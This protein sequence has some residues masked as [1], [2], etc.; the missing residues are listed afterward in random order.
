M[1]TKLSN[2]VFINAILNLEDTLVSDVSTYK[3]CFSDLLLGGYGHI[4]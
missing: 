1:K 4:H 2:Y 3:K